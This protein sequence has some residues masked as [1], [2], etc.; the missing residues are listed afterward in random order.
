MKLKIAGLFISLMLISI[1]ISAYSFW[2]AAQPVAKISFPLGNVLVL[3]KGKKRMQK[4]GFN[5]KLFTGDKIK[6][7]KQARC[8]IKYTDGSIVRIDQQSIYTIEKA[9]ITKKEKKVESSLSIGRLWANIK[10][11]ASSSDNWFLRGPSAVVAVRGTVYRMDT[12]DD[13]SSKVLVYEGSVNVGPPSWAPGAGTQGQKPGAP[14]RVQ[15]PSVVK[16]PSVVSLDEWVEIV[17]AQQQIII[18]PDGSFQ[19]SDFDLAADAQSSWVKWN[20][21]RD[22]LIK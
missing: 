6:T 4:A 10:K 7:E 22:K 20:M 17:K 2:D 21:E 1:A 5:Q 18:K 11:L 19:K 16:G 3:K 14:Q 12:M 13:K 9:Q 15:G 8:E